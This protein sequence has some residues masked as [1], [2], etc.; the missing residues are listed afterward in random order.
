MYLQQGRVA[1]AK[2]ALKRSLD[3]KVND[4]AEKTMAASLRS[5]GTPADAIPFALKAVDLNPTESSNWL[6]LGD[7][8][9]L[10]RGY[11]SEAT[12]AYT[13]AVN[14]EE[15][16]LKDYPVDGPK[17]MTLALCRSQS[18]RTSDGYVS[19]RESGALSR[20]SG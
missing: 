7:C 9:S 5:E 13:Q 12:K 15:Q 19:H 16:Q 2:L 6:E 4:W 20:P 11:R 18:W 10:A 8:Y 17:W 3:L 1:E 14:A